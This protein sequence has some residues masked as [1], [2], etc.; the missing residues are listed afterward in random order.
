MAHFARI[1]NNNIVT[2]VV[3]VPDEQEQRGQDF[4][5]NDLGFGGTWI[6]TSF[7]TVAN[8]HLAGGTPFRKNYATIGAVWDAER[9]AFYKVQP[10]SSWI[11]NEETCRWE[12]PTPRPQNDLFYN[13]DEPSKSWVEVAFENLQR[14]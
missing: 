11:L 9:D 7:N 10:F 14:L 3:V 13:W 5:A 1:N 12:P 4:L 6:K 8:K 2:N